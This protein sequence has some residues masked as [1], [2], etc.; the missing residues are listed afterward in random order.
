VFHVIGGD[1]DAAEFVMVAGADFAEAEV[2][3]D[4]L[5]GLDAAEGLDGD[6]GAVGDAGR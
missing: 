6:G 1:F 3:E 4:V 2:A 5:G